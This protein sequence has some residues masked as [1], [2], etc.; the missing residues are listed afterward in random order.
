MDYDVDWNTRALAQPSY[1]KG[2][3]PATA[4]VIVDEF[5]RCPNCEGNISPEVT[6]SVYTDRDVIWGGDDDRTAP[7]ICAKCDSH[8]K[9]FVEE[10]AFRTIGPTQLPEPQ[11]NQEHTHF[12]PIEDS[13][14]YIVVNTYH[15]SIRE[16]TPPEDGSVRRAHGMG[17]DT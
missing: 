17:F 9:I 6:D 15:I 1:R 4:S 2:I 3:A 14:N 10:K 8:L 12:I 7:H 13:E 16:T 11:N 5:G